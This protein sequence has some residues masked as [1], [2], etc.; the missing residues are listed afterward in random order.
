MKKSPILICLYAYFP[1]ENANT[2][3]LLPLIKKLSEKYEVH[4]LTKN[5]DNTA[6]CH[7]VM[8]GIH[9]H[10]YS[11]SGRIVSKIQMFAG[12]D[13]KKARAW[14]K[15]A[16]THTVTPICRVL[17]RF[18]VFQKNEQKLMC[19]LINDIQFAFVMTTCEDFASHENMLFVKKKY[20]INTPWIAYF[21]DPH[22][23]FVAYKDTCGEI[24]EKEIDV[25]R[26]S[27]LILV[28]EEIY[29]E[30]QTNEFAPYLYKTKPFRFGNF[31]C[32]DKPLL[33]DIF[34]K[35]KINCVY[36]GSLLNESVRNPGYFYSIINEVDDRFVF[37]IICNN[38][39]KANKALYDKTV[40][41]T[42][43]V[44]WYHNLPLEECLGIMC[45]ADILINL[46]NRTVNQTPSKVF[47]YIGTGNPIVNFYSLEGDTSKRYLERYEHAI[48][49]FE[50]KDRIKDNAKLFQEF[51]AEHN[52]RRIGR[53]QLQTLYNE[54]Q[55]DLV[56]KD[57]LKIIDSYIKK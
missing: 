54:Y 1:F 47:D 12:M 18:P 51:A 27:D 2:N 36:V 13:K 45:H 57:T 34:V 32:I 7:E 21:M 6:P 48:H 10:R 25:Y 33:K 5:R 4:I 53:E 26:E 42:D 38:L 11:D 52:G 56:T 55:S 41:R 16:L 14:Y 9:V 39:T 23:K 20:G 17:Y 37:H 3:V 43:R 46:G 8:D 49:I 44:R 40:M 29:A 19:K 28:T 15:N 24:L 31:R 35:D 50:D 30:N 22:A